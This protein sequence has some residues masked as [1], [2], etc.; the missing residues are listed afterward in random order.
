MVSRSGKMLWASPRSVLQAGS[1]QNRFLAVQ[2]IGY[3][4]YIN[5]IAEGLGVDPEDWMKPAPSEWRE[6][7][8]KWSR[9]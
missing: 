7:K 6:R 5:R 2:V 3:F 1:C 9:S 8:A 4:N